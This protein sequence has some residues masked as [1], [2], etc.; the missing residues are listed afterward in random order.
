MK[1]RMIFDYSKLKG[2]MKEKDYTQKNAAEDLNIDKSTF[3]LKINN[4]G[5]FSQNEIFIL[6]GKLDILKRDIQDYFFT[7]KV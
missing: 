4:N 6:A 3:N 5:Y 7:L 2:K 1:N